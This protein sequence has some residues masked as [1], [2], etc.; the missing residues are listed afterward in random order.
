MNLRLS[1]RF[2]LNCLWLSCACHTR[3]SLWPGRALSR[4]VQVYSAPFT[5]WVI[6]H[7]VMDEQWVAEHPLRACNVLPLP[8]ICCDL[9]VLDLRHSLLPMPS[10]SYQVSRSI[11]SDPWHWHTPLSCPNLVK[12]STVWFYLQDKFW[13]RKKP[14]HIYKFCYTQLCDCMCWCKLLVSVFWSQSNSDVKGQGRH[15]AHALLRPLLKNPR[16]QCSSMPPRLGRSLS[17]SVP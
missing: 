14:T 5:V 8:C 12:V 2:T 15:T 17:A 1:C 9:S 6:N 7:R 13:D 10:L 4:W 11:G 3:C 16:W